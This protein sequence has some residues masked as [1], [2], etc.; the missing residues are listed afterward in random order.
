LLSGPLLILDPDFAIS[1]LSNHELYREESAFFRTVNHAPLNVEI[2]QK[3]SRELLNGVQSQRTDAGNT[4]SAEWG[5]RG[6]LN[7]QGWGVWL[8]RAHF[9]AFLNASGSHEIDSYIDRFVRLRTIRH[10]LRGRIG[11]APSRFRRQMRAKLGQLIRQNPSSLKHDLVHMIRGVAGELEDHEIGEL[12]LRLVQSVVAFAGSALEMAVLMNLQNGALV[13]N[14]P[15][16]YIAE[17]LRMYPTSWRMVRVAKTPHEID[18][19]QVNTG[20]EIIIGTSA[21]HRHPIFFANPNKFDVARFEVAPGERTPHLLAFG[22]GRGM[23]PGRNVA[24]SVISDAIQYIFG[25]YE[26]TLRNPRTGKPYV[27][28]LLIPPLISFRYS[29]MTR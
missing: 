3:L 21:I 5:E 25:N 7:T 9:R 17:V 24:I 18:G 13:P 26:L 19:I 1:V 8:M 2:R 28:S 27:R 20:Q 16:A 23:C 11:Q 29:R 10:E 22:H 4:I 14:S 6:S 12:Y 15:R